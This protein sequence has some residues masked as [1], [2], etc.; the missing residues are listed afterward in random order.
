MFNTWVSLSLLHTG[1]KDR[2]CQKLTRRWNIGRLLSRQLHLYELTVSRMRMIQYCGWHGA[3]RRFL[4]RWHKP[5]KLLWIVW[6]EGRKKQG[7]AKYNVLVNAGRNLLYAMITFKILNYAY[8]YVFIK[9][10]FQNHWF[11][12]T[13]Y[14][15]WMDC[16]ETYHF[17]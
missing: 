10:A 1:Y 3:V 8:F 14:F 7:V 5:R 6:R 9:K 15:A 17:A 16:K 4:S 13:D 2:H 11:T 12:E